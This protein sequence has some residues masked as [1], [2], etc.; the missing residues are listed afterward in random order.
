M[1]KFKIILTIVAFVYLFIGALLFVS[2]SLAEGE[3]TVPTIV[4]YSNFDEIP[5]SIDYDPLLWA[6]LYNPDVNLADELD[7]GQN[8]CS[9]STSLTFPKD[10]IEISSVSF[11]VDTDNN[12]SNDA[13]TINFKK[14]FSPCTT[15]IW[16]NLFYVTFSP[17]AIGTGTIHF[18]TTQEVTGGDDDVTVLTSGVYDDVPVVTVAATEIQPEP[19]IT[20][21]LPG[22]TTVT[23][24]PSTATSTKKSS[25]TSSSAAAAKI[26]TKP[27]KS[28]FKT[29]TL[30]KLEFGPS[31]VLDK[32]NSRSN[33]A[34]FTG[35]GEP[36]SKM[37]L[38]INSQNEIFTDTTSDATGAWT[39]TI[40]DWLEDG[41]HS[42]TIWAEKD[43]KISPKFSSNFVISSYAK[44]Q[45]AIGDTYPETSIKPVVT[46]PKKVSKLDALLNNKFFWGYV[47]VGLII[48]ALFIVLLIKSRRKKK[49]ANIDI[50]SS[51]TGGTATPTDVSQNLPPEAPTFQ[52]PQFHSPQPQNSVAPNTTT[53]TSTPQNPPSPNGPRLDI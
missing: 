27:E 31:A 52:A 46:P 19:E 23:P 47:G 40:T 11:T 29:P 15:E 16:T 42:I 18:L 51:G 39:K 44:D 30:T 28:A 43:N 36:N 22:R 26:A 49:N 4:G 1:R 12:Y 37:L 38:L 48:I 8:I 9:V 33:G 53:P 34:V 41:S 5:L 32:T 50:P 21:T 20:Q 7:V 14:T 17:K 10:L 24:H 3:P 45:I 25:G 35:T 13:G 6:G 2:T